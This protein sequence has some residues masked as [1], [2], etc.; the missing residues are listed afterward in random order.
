MSIRQR[1]QILANMSVS[2][3]RKIAANPKKYPDKLRLARLK[4]IGMAL[5]VFPSSPKQREI[6]QLIRNI[7][8]MPFDKWQ[9]K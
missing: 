7:E 1:I 2:E 6:S 4:L 3:A 9:I 8:A 5:R